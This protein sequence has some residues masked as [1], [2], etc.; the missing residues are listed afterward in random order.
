[1]GVRTDTLIGHGAVSRQTVLEMASGVRRAMAA[2]PELHQAVGLSISGIA[3]PGGATTEKPVGLVWI[4]L[5][6][7]EG[8][9]AWEHHFNGD[10]GQIKAQAA[11][12][13]LAHL[14]D[15]LKD[16]PLQ[17]T[18]VEAKTGSSGEPIPQSF[19][20]QGRSY[21]V[22][23]IGRRWNDAAGQHILV[24]T[25]EQHTVELVRSA[26]GSAWFL[27]TGNLPPAHV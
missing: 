25:A 1:L 4:G 9:W 27:N 20:W 21:L 18:Q 19:T 11:E 16:S 3:G 10:R 22:T 15:Y 14:A 13:A 7:E 5:S 8:D 12:E 6:A 23:D 17:P 24:M 26:D 2:L